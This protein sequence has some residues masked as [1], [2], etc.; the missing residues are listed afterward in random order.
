MSG[1]KKIQLFD[2]QS[3]NGNSAEFIIDFAS[4]ESDIEISGDF[5][6]GTVTIQRLSQ[7]G[8]TWIDSRDLSRT[9]VNI[10]QNE[11]I[12]IILPYNV[13]LRLVLA[14]A[15]GAPDLNAWIIRAGERR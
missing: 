1:G 2:G 8:T 6:N 11:I 14:G 7:D 5:D 9:V 15:T 10:T 13:T 12:P 4:A 3:A